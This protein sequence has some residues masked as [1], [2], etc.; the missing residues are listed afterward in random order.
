MVG[1]RAKRPWPGGSPGSEGSRRERLHGLRQS[2]RPPCLDT[3]PGARTLAAIFGG[4]QA[5]QA[6]LWAHDIQVGDRPVNNLLIAIAVFV[7]TVLG[8]LFAVPHFIDWNS[9]RSTFEE[10]ARNVIGRE[11]RINGIPRTI[12]GVLREGF[13][14]PMGP[15]DFY[16]PF[17]RAPVVA[18]PIAARRAQWLG[19]IGRLQPGVSQDAASREVERIWAQLVR[20]YPAD[21]GTLGASAMPL[22]DS[23]VGDTR[24]PL[25]VLMASA[26]LVLLITCANLAATLMSRALSRRKEFAVRIA[27]SKLLARRAGT[28]LQTLVIDEGFGSQDGQ[29]REKLVGAIRS[30]QDDFEKI[31]VITH[32]E[33]LKDEFPTRINIVK[34]NSGSRIVMQDDM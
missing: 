2:A 30:I 24:T 8:A 12:V 32:I 19:L 33:E 26:A 29:G 22:R 6:Q 5:L 9:Y 20:D 15:V 27:L 1:C 31:L 23:M 14:G 10:E 3:A 11:V 16:L 13:I 34:T 17:D 28:Q 25:L 21:N 7:I 18:N 4:P